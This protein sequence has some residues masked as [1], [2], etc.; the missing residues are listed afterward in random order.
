MPHRGERSRSIR[1]DHG[2]SEKRWDLT[3]STVLSF[4]CATGDGVT[5]HF[6]RKR[7]LSILTTR[8]IQPRNRGTKNLEVQNIL[9][10][11]ASRR[12]KLGSMDEIYQADQHGHLPEVEKKNGYITRQGQGPNS[13]D[14]PRGLMQP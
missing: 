12:R 14:G 7:C 6:S 1:E 11:T 2:K 10:S 5:I 4:I 8:A 3:C 9:K 13:C